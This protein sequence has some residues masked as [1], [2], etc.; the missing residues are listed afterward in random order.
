[1][2]FKKSAIVLASAA[3][4][5]VAAC[6]GGGS[7]DKKSDSSG[8]PNV[9]TQDAGSGQNAKAT[10]PAA[11]VSGAAKGGTLN[12]VSSVAP[13]TFDPTRVYY[14]DT[15]AIMSNL[16]TRSLTQYQYDP[17]TKNMVLVPDMATNLGEPS[18]DFKSWKFT[19]RPG[20]KYEDGTPVK[21]EDIAY[22]VKRSFAIEELPDG[23]TYNTQF[24]LDGDKY[25]GPYKDGD[26]YKGVEVSGNTITILMRRPFGDMPYLASFPQYT[27]IPKAKDTDPKKYEFHPLATGPYKFVSYRSGTSLKLTKNTQWD[28]AT[29]T[30]R[31]QYVDGWNFTWGEDSTKTDN[32]LINDQGQ[33]QTTLTY[34]NVLAADY[35][36]A[37]QSAA[38]RVVSGTQPCTFMWFIDM[39]KIT[40]LKV[41]Q[42]LGYAYPY[43]AAWRA[44]GEVENV[45]RIGGTTILPP[46]TAGR[47]E[48]DPLGTGGTKTDPAK[49]KA[50][51]KEAGAEGFEIKYLYATDDP[52]SVA[53]K[54]QIAEG[55]KAGGFK[56]TPIASTTAK[57]RDDRVN[58]NG[59]QNVRSSG[60]CSDWPTGGSWFPPNWDGSLVGTPGMPN[61]A[62]F[63][64]TDTDAMLNKILDTQSGPEA[65]KSWGELDKLIETK[66]YPAVVTGYGGV[67]MLHGSKVGGMNDN[68]VYGMPTFADMFVKQ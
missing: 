42:A 16:V 48:Y 10:A 22:A 47:L 36:K 2:Q 30:T 31:H 61:Q 56:A 68:N 58:P 19:L 59:P 49:S 66:Y 12:V 55:L 35:D 57:I 23:P 25:K 6:G 54:D 60:W 7:S 63:K 37:K 1:M 14:V 40:N 51:L 64:E 15:A 5:T 4:L 38:D 34:D 39:R 32:L 21:A 50:L 29:D 52:Q 62:M 11:E 28:P 43:R 44:A 27:G 41:R 26:N 20:L 8:K 65:A 24:F 45:T 46:G 33:A 9:A 17:K 67:A 53:A 3:L 18:A 13:N